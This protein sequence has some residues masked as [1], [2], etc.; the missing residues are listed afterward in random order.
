MQGI[1]IS[2]SRKTA[3]VFSGGLQGGK[4]SLQGG[5]GKIQ[6][7]KAK[8]QGSSPKLAVTSNPM[9]YTLAGLGGV[10]VLGDN[11]TGNNT[12]NGG[13]DGGSGSSFVDTSAARNATLSQIDSLARQLENMNASSQGEYDQLI[14]QYLEEN[15]QNRANYEKQVA[16][17]EN[18]RSGGISQSL[19]AAAQGGRGLRSTLAAMG[20]LGGTGELLANRAVA[21]VA[22]NDIG[23]VNETFETN[24]GN[25][26]SAWEKTE[27]EQRQR[28]EDARTAL[29]NAKVKNAGSI[30]SQRQGLFKDM[31]GFWEQ[32]GN[33]SEAANWMSKISGQNPTIEAA[34]RTSTP[35]FQRSSAAFSPAA[36][37]N[38]LA[39][40][41]DM[42]VQ[43]SAGN[44]GLTMNSPIYAA[45]SR[46]EEY[47]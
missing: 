33:K 14:R 35:T 31:A 29:N 32:A 17:N 18:T 11:N 20:A 34:S 24:A 38:Y 30:A 27:R 13:G 40:N 42:A 16:S 21:K 19:A 22:N 15:S 1:P 2:G 23:G 37:K 3:G 46:R 47:A 41:Q 5:S 45:Q 36:L 26:N 4:V 25:L 43:T 10:N 12:G 28:D 9:N 44:N 39:G 7:S 8:V 6:G